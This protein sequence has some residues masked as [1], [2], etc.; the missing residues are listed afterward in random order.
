MRTNVYKEKILDLLKKSHLLS[1]PAIQEKIPKA[2]FSTIFRNLQ[3][4]C[5][6]GV[7]R[8]VTISKDS[9]LYEMAEPN[10]RHDHFVCTDCGTIES[11]HLPKKIISKGTV[12]D[13]LVRG[14]CGDCV[15]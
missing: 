9:I 12:D 2:D 14:T 15:K 10:H 3:N 1:I 5:T 7:V 8:K 6:A 13:V 4:L 11:I